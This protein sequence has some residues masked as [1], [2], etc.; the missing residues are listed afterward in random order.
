M[1]KIITIIILFLIYQNSNAQTYRPFI[2]PGLTWDVFQFD[3]TSIC[4]YSSAVRYFFGNDTVI[5]GQQ[6]T[7]VQGWNIISTLPNPFCP[8]YIVVGNS[9][10]SGYSHLLRED[11]IAKRL[12]KYDQSSGTDQLLLDFS[13]VPGDTLYNTLWGPL[14]ID[15]ILPITLDDGSVSKI[16]HLNSFEFYIEG[17]GASNGGLTEFVQ[18]SG[19]WPTELL[20]VSENHINLFGSPGMCQMITDVAENK[21]VSVMDIF[22]NPSNG[23]IKLTS[24]AVYTEALKYCMFNVFGQP[25][26]NGE[27]HFTDDASELNLDDFSE[28]IYFLRMENERQKSFSC[29]IVLSR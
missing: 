3:G 6:Y 2:R 20:C 12:Y 11:T 4:Q 28:G 13:L 9:T 14:I 23:K 1:K 18:L 26:K 24:P 16:F 29:K 17:V 22:P 10:G 15:T 21:T 8:P 7:K 25:I 27:L 19:V 5:Q